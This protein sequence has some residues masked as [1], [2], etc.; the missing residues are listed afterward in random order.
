MTSRS[1]FSDTIVKNIISISANYEVSKLRISDKIKLHTNV[2]STKG[3]VVPKHT[4]VE[5]EK[6]IPPKHTGITELRL[7][8]PDNELIKLWYES[9]DEFE[10]EIL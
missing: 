4:I 10:H 8:A 5:V 2:H 9:E 1:M 6:V 3:L 7:R